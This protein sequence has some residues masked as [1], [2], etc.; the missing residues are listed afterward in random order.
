MRGTNGELTR[1][2]R[3]WLYVHAVLCSAPGSCS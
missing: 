3:F 2:A 1:S